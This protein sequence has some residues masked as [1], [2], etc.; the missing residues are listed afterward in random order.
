MGRKIHNLLIQRLHNM[1]R[2][3]HDVKVV[4]LESKEA[5]KKYGLSGIE[6][7]K[8]AEKKAKETGKPIEMVLDSM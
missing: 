3:K 7:Y 5:W 4:F 8:Y 6:L 2:Q 1:Q